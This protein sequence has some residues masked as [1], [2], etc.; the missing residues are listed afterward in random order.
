MNSLYHQSEAERQATATARAIAA[1]TNIAQTA[2]AEAVAFSEESQATRTA[3]AADANA[4][5]T[6]NAASA[7]ATATA[8]AVSANATATAQAATAEENRCRDVTFYSFEASSEPILWPDIEYWYVTD[9][10]WPQVRATW[11]V[12]LPDTIATGVQPCAWDSVAL[13]TL[14]G[15]AVNDEMVKLQRDGAFVERVQPGESVDLV[16]YF[17]RLQ[18]PNSGEWVLV[19]N[20]ISLFDQ[21]HLKLDAG[22]WVKVVTPTPVSTKQES[23]L[24]YDDG[25]AE[26]GFVAGPSVLGTV[27]FSTPS[28]SQVL[29]LKFYVWGEMKNVRVHVLDAN[30]KSVYSRIVMPSPRWF[31]VDTSGDNV[32]VNGD[33]YAG[34]QWISEAPNGPWLGVDTD[35]PY[36]KRSHL[37]LEGRLFYKGSGNLDEQKEDYMIRIEVGT[38]GGS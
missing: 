22:D 25:S 31:E 9:K 20:D 11:V 3:Q 18:A 23:Q 15:E 33:F 34:W 21:P 7:N 2:T 1:A 8:N 35:P 37:G 38:A 19:V 27:K 17:P 6:V 14:S 28:R 32:F 4:T 26:F 30:Q 24:S 12:A 36:N 16:L 29:K 5:A 13:R 10:L